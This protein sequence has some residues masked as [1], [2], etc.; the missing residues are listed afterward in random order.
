MPCYKGR[1]AFFCP[2]ICSLLEKAATSGAASSAIKASA[3][4]MLIKRTSLGAN[5]P[6]IMVYILLSLRPHSRQSVASS[7]GSMHSKLG[8]QNTYKCSVGPFFYPSPR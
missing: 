1:E 7:L 4:E 8:Q 6:V 5:E 2:Q 3:P